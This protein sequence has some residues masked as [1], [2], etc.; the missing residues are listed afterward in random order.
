MTKKRT[1]KIDGPF[2]PLLIATI[3]SP[4]WRAMSHGAH[5]L[6]VALKRRYNPSIDN[7]G[8]IFLSLRR[9]AQELQSHPDYIARWY[10]E[11]QHYGFVVQI[12]PGCLGADGKGKTAHWRLTELAYRS[13]PPTRDFLRWDGTPFMNRKTES[14]PTDVGRGDPQ[15]W[16]SGD[17]QM[18]VSRRKNANRRGNPA[19]ECDA[20]EM[21]LID[22]LTK[23]R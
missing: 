19:D 5:S 3:D 10:R 8:E 1:S 2:V 16:A 21:F 9:A 20:I 23:S 13:K 22:S 11:L 17:P 4:A 12:Q 15:M 18:W 14:R 7:N 6:Y